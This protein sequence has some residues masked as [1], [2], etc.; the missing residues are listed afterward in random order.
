MNGLR[1][2]GVGIYIYKLEQISVRMRTKIEEEEEEEEARG[3][4]CQEN[5]CT[6]QHRY[7]VLLSTKNV[8]VSVVDST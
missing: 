4:T 1:V 5:P 2:C 7:T 6:R 8:H 3:Q